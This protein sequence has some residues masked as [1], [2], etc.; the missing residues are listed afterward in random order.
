MKPWE[1]WKS[2]RRFDGKRR[3]TTKDTATC[4]KLHHRYPTK[5]EAERV[6]RT[7]KRQGIICRVTKRAA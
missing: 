6:A 1:I 7:M 2:V 3:L 4:T 5:K